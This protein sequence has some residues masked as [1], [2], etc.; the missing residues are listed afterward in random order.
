[1]IATIK[2]LEIRGKEK[3]VSQKTHREYLIVR[4]EDETGKSTELLDW[5]VENL[6][7]YK[8]RSIADFE[9]NLDI[10]KYINISVKDFKIH[11]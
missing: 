10:G 7:R 11:E 3:K 2:N 6:E 8:Q 9:L 1:M 5:N 4:V